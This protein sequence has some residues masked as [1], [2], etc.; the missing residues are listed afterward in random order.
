MEPDLSVRGHIIDMSLL[1]NDRQQPAGS[2]TS[3]I[4]TVCVFALGLACVPALA[5]S[6][7]VVELPTIGDPW[8]QVIS[9]QQERRLGQEFMRRL[10]HQ[11]SLIDE[12]E[13]QEY[14]QFLGYSL[15]AHSD[16]PTQEFTF[17]IVDHP[18]INA[19]AAPGGYIGVNSGL[20]TAA[21]SE[22]ELAAVL[23]HEIAHVTQR[24]V[25]RSF[26][27]A[28]Q[29][30]LPSAAVLIAAIL[31]GTQSP[32]LGQAALTVGIAGSTQSQLNFTR[33]NESEA[34]RVGIQILARAGFDPRSVP[35][36]FERL[37]KASRLYGDGPPEFLR[38][39]P[40]TVSRIADSRSRA[41][42]YPVKPLREQLSFELVRAKLQVKA[43]QNP[44]KAAE[45][46]AARLESGQ[47]RNES[48]TR[49]GYALALH[50][51][52]NYTGA[53]E[54]LQ[55]LLGEDPDEIA[56]RI[57]LAKVEEAA[58]HLSRAFKI[59][60][61]T[62]E[63]YPGNHPVTVAYSQALITAQKGAEAQRLLQAHIR[64]RAP[65]PTLYQLLARAAGQA[66]MRADA[67]EAIAEYYYLN[68]DTPTAIEQLRLAL[69]TLGESYY[70]TARIQARL[71]ELQHELIRAAKTGS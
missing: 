35:T 23:A 25:A 67:F 46:F 47:Y 36:F 20:I 56:Y 58:G 29:L 24:H 16:D 48:A 15:V 66:G 10:R 14:I 32:E 42:Q 7:E 50:A 62:V 28:R 33:A 2:L 6:T 63:L 34:D 19:F 40:V 21:E 8:G 69:R 30:S 64:S 70:E 61:E 18:S 71:R 1:S 39:H 9:P 26:D 53:R 3:R 41:E 68:G 65:D 59:Y 60:S 55:R 49:Y 38:T 13:I 51:T 27:A 12:P 11:V 31:L 37:Q 45:K 44:A 54:Q 5:L 57:A 43:E 4:A 22:S 52:R 17:F